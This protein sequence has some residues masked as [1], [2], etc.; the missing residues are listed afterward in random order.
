MK[1]RKKRQADPYAEESSD[2]EEE[3]AP[4]KY[5][6]SDFPHFHQNSTQHYLRMGPSCFDA[7]Y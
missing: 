5:A 1:A 7:K 3:E 6:F 2:G 4:G